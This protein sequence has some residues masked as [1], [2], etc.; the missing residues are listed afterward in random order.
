MPAGSRTAHRMDHLDPRVGLPDAHQL[1]DGFGRVLQVGIH[2][3]HRVAAR[4]PQARQHTGRNTK[5]PRHVN[6]PD[7][8][9]AVDFLPQNLFRV[10]GGGIVDEDQLVTAKVSR[11]Q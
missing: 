3:D 11:G 4:V 10:I 2:V 7:I 8:V 9:A 5:I 1:G 6:Q